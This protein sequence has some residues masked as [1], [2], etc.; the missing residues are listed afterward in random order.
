MDPNS[1]D[2][3]ELLGAAIAAADQEGIPIV[4]VSTIVHQQDGFID[5]LT[6][7]QFFATIFKTCWCVCWAAKVWTFSLGWSYVEA[8]EKKRI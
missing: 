8:M 5:R 2:L 7:T 1:D 3:A 4:S 6:F